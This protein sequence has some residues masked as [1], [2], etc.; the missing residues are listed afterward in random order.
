MFNIYVNDIAE[1]VSDTCIVLY[2]DDTSLFVSDNDLDDL[3]Q[4]SRSILSK[5][6]SWSRDNA[7]TINSS[8]S[9]A[10][11]F[12][13]R[14]RQSY[15]N[16]ELLLDGAPIEIVTKYKVLGVTLSEDMNWTYH[17][18]QIMKSLSSAAG[19]LSRCRHFFPEKVK[20]YIYYALFQSHLNYC[21]LV[22]ATTTKRNLHALLQLQ[23]RALRHVANVPYFHSTAQLFESYNI[24]QVTNIYEYRLLHSFC[25]GS[26]KFQI[27][28]KNTSRLEYDK[29]DARTRSKD[30]WLVPY[31]RT[32]YLM[33]SLRHTLPS[34][35]NKFGKEIVMTN[36]LTRKQLRAYFCKEIFEM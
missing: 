36:T 34:L 29:S 17:I 15:L 7:L 2:A 9:K 10:I 18:E 12:K 32:N 22:W 19:A 25:F 16:E 13:A 14:G 21:A 24:I 27:F 31:R 20:L 28:L 8:K 3:L 5:L 23:K 33:Q 26:E 30:R 11:L 1:I 4:R 35:F 6:S